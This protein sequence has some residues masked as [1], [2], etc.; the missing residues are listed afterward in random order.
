M[1]HPEAG[2]KIHGKPNDELVLGLLLAILIGLVLGAGL[3][4]LAML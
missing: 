3:A 1:K 2:S 4:G